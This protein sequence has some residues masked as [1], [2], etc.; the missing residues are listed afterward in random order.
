MES[1]L[2]G[3]MLVL[4]LA[5]AAAAGIALL[6]GL[7]RVSGRGAAGADSSHGPDAAVGPPGRVS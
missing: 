3:T 4:A 1:L 2:S 7:F 6:I 5:V